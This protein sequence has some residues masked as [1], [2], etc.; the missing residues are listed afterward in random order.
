VKMNY[1]QDPAVAARAGAASDQPTHILADRAELQHATKIATFY[2]KPVR[3]WQ[4]GNQVQA[5]VIEVAQA[6]KRLTARGEGSAPGQVHTVLSA[7]EGDVSGKPGARPQA[8]CSATAARAGAA[9][10]GA[11]AEAKSPEVV[12]IA[13]G[14]LIYSDSLRQ[15]D[16]TG[17]F[18]ADTVDGTIRA[19]SGTVFMQKTANAGSDAD[20]AVPSLGGNLDRVV[21]AGH[22]ELDKPGM[23]ATG[24]RLVYT[25]SDRIVLLTGDAKAPPKAV[26]AQGS[27][28][29]AALRFNSCDGSVEALGGAGERVLTDA[30]IGNEE[31][32]DK[33]KR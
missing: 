21:A 17:G 20:S 2:G 5:P 31:K 27:T 4:G 15:A 6:E 16:F 25:A 12:R 3:M 10:A 26:G 30:R 13:S 33:G 23:H 22:V 9:K 14:G 24:E 32:K 18:R 28:T 19:G 8:A 1:V 7:W 29:G 11:G